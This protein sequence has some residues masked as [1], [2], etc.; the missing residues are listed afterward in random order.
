MQLVKSIVAE[1]PDADWPVQTQNL[2]LT[3]VGKGWANHPA[4]RMWQD[5]VGALAVYHDACLI[6]WEAR[7][8][9][10][11]MPPLSVRGQH[12]LPDWF[13]D[14]AFHASHR[15]N[16]LRKQLEWYGQFG[17]TESHDLEYVWPR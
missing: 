7:G 16:L 5:H 6:V 8:Y 11:N 15:S 4:R 10:N 13:G 12:K 9:Q 14:E 1:H 2:D 3:F 17:W